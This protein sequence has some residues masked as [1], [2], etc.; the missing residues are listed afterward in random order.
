MMRRPFTNLV[1]TSART[2]VYTLSQFQAQGFEQHSSV[3]SGDSNIFSNLTTYTLLP[4]WTTAGRYGDTVGPR[5]S[6]A[7]IMNT[8]RYGP[9]ALS[10]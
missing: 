10:T 7:Q 2:E 1:N 4:Q 5:Y 9:G 3:I 8:S 6:V